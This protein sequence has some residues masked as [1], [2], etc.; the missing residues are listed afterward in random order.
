[1][2]GLELCLEGE[3]NKAMLIVV[4]FC[5]VLGLCCAGYHLGVR[6]EMLQMLMGN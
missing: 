2:V 1:M 4:C 3:K 5:R 6:E